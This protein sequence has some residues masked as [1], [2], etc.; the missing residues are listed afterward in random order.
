MEAIVLARANAWAEAFPSGRIESDL[1]PT[2]QAELRASG[3]DFLQIYRRQGT[4]WR[5]A[6]ET[7]PTGVLGV[8]PIDLAS[9]LEAALKKDHLVRSSHGALAGVASAGPDRVL[10]VGMLSRPTTSRRSTG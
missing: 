7:R 9:E 4:T 2:V 5:L 10:V 6:D 3:L 8:V 1:R